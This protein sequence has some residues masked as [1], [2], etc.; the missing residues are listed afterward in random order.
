MLSL[1]LVRPKSACLFLVL[2]ANT[3]ARKILKTFISKNIQSKGTGHKTTSFT[4]RRS[5]LC[6][7]AGGPEATAADENAST[8][9]G[10]GMANIVTSPGELYTQPLLLSKDRDPATAFF[11]RLLKGTAV[12]LARELTGVYEVVTFLVPAPKEY[13]PIL[14]PTTTFTDWDT[15]KPQDVW[16]FPDAGLF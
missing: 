7:D 16:R 2:P 8:K 4:V 5:R 15:R 11:G 10:R 9:S 14:G 3:T 13:R 12:F 6:F 1:R